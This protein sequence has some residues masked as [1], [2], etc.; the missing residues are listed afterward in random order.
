[1]HLTKPAEAGHTNLK[2]NGPLKSSHKSVQ[3]ALIPI[4]MALIIAPCIA[5]GQMDT[6]L[7]GPI[8]DLPAIN[9]T[10]SGRIKII[11]T[12]ERDPGELE[13]VIYELEEAGDSLFASSKMKYRGPDL[14]T[15]VSG[16][17]NGFYYYRVRAFNQTREQYSEWSPTVLVAVQHHSLNL[18]FTLF[19][20]GG[21]VFI[22]T[23]L[24]VIVGARKH[25]RANQEKN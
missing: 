8:I 4:L 1:M 16:L 20:I 19:T 6:V 17:D 11:W 23:A 3:F 14:A 22:M 25:S 18:A 24:V 2:T 9:E 15:Y 10:S 7:P 21:V 12:I 13:S 5:F